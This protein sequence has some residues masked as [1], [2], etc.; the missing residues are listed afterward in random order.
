MNSKCSATATPLASNLQ[1][2]FA[3]TAST[4]VTTF[5]FISWFIIKCCLASAACVL[6]MVAVVYAEWNTAEHTILKYT[7]TDPL[8]GGAFLSWNSHN[9][10]VAIRAS[11]LDRLFTCLHLN[12]A[13]R[14]IVSSHFDNNWSRGHH[15]RLTVHRL[16]L[17]ITRLRLTVT[18]LW[19]T[20]TWLLHRLTIRLLIHLFF[21]LL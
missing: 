16:R 14:V 13:C 5:T 10:L 6:E 21:Y 20:I 7:T 12:H 4:A 3:W 19:L 8:L 2:W 17:T 1:S 15:L 11:N 18:G 9:I